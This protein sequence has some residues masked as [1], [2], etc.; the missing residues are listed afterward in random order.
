MR[1]YTGTRDFRGATDTKADA[2]EILS[3]ELFYDIGNAIVTGGARRRSRFECTRS[4]IEIIVNDHDI[5][6]SQFIKVHQLADRRTGGIHE[7]SG[8][9]QE[10]FV[11]TDLSFAN[12]G[13]HFFMRLKRIAA[14]CLLE[15]IKAKKA[16]VVTGESVIVAWIAEADDELHTLYELVS[17]MSLFC[18]LVRVS[19]RSEKAKEASEAV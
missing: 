11:P 7:G 3:A 9:D 17:G 14:P 10:D 13:G 6:G 15:V 1:R 5:F 16:G 4:D 18:V 8:L 12:F 2:E 19:I